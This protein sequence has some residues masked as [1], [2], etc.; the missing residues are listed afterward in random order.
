MRGASFILVTHLST[1]RGLVLQREPTRYSVLHPNRLIP[2][3]TRD[4]HRTSNG[5][6]GGNRTHTLLRE[7]VFLHTTVFTA[8]PLVVRALDYPF[9]H[10]VICLGAPRLVSTPS[11]ITKGLA[12]DYHFRGFPDFEAF[13]SHSF[14]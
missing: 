13:Y 4:K 6:N 5:A 12:R 14:P 10:S 7:T 3:Y 9:T 8:N 1:L 2:R 11:L